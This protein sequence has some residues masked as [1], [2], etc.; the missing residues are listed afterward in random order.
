MADKESFLVRQRRARP[1]LDHIVRAGEAYTE[2]YGSQHAAAIT[3]FSVLSLFPLLMISFAVGGFVLAGNAALL[4][5]MKNGITDAVPAGLDEIVNDVIDEAIESRGAV[6]VLGLLAALYSGLGWMQN[7]RDAL[8]AQWGLE[9]KQRPFLSTIL[10][11]V[12]ALFGLGLALAVSFGLSA[13]G[14]GLGSWLLGLVGLS[15]DAWALFLLRLATIVLS[16][17]ANWLVFLWVLSRLPRERVSARS[18]ARGAIA[19]AIGFELLKQGFTIYL[20]MVTN[21]S[22]G[23][24]FGPIIGLLLFANL[25]SRYLL[26]ITAWTATAKENIVPRASLAPPPAVISPRVVVRK[27]PTARGA[28][29]LFGAGAVLGLLLRKR[30]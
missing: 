28:L 15:D 14:S 26:F 9:H 18:A 8:T 12:L 27:G 2:R 29:G 3:Y 4:T 13:A 7:L 10:K 19:A 23:R 21:S 25:V 30:R 16:L 17:A 22:S 5:E 24:V 11:D 6:G 20:E 1:W